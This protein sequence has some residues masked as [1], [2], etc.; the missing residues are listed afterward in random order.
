[1]KLITRDTDYAIRALV[2]IGRSDKAIISVSELVRE[3]KIPKPFLRKILQILNK[4][5]L[6]R[7]Y[8]GNKGGFI[9]KKGLEKIF[10]LD[11]IKIFQGSLR[12]N[13]CFLRK[14]ICPN[15]K[16]CLLKKKIDKIQ[17]LVTSELENIDLKSLF[18]K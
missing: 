10:L 16:T 6:L 18:E 7:S 15:I 14:S 1:M 13:E 4:K 3:L 11:L 8:K 9:L 5:N 2:F 17:K 12:L